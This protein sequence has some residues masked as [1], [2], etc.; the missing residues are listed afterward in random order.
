M[1]SFSTWSHRSFRAFAFAGLVLSGFSAAC[2]APPA[3][4]AASVKLTRLD[5]RVRV[6]I[7]GHLFTEY[8][9]R[10]TPKPYLYPIVDATGATY[11]RNWPMKSVPG[12]IHDHD[13]HRSVWFAHGLVNGHDF[14][15]ELPDN[16]TGRIV[17][18]DILEQ[19]DGAT[20][21]LRVRSQWISGDGQP[22]CTDET[23]YRFQRVPE[24][25]FLDCEITLIA[26]HGQVV[27]GDTEEGALGV[28]V[29]EGIRLSVGKGKTRHRGT[30]HIVNANGDRDKVA[31]GKRAPWCDYS[32]TVDG[33]QI[34]IAIFD[35]PANPS[36]PTWWHVR[37]Y[38]LFAAN[39]FGKHDF[40]KLKDQP[41]AGNI[42]IPADGHLTL[43]YRIFF[44]HGDESSARVADL[45]RAY[46][47]GH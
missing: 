40:E 18:D 16:K 26:S 45:Y 37:D 11:T 22:I 20:G 41:D 29:N 34:G 6:E 42:T 19:R 27:L 21:L 3:P 10:D 9:F 47:Q 43:R 17:Y 12:E 36:H 25:Y 44:H 24:G 8:R 30:G 33:R 13:W 28:R 5:D 7:D 1:I 35:H 2:A 46:T 31:W 23:S 38:G 32:G 14:W 4:S 15:R 39:P